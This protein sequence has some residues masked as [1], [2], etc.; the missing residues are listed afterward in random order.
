[1]RAAH[2]GCSNGEQQSPQTCGMPAL[3]TGLSEPRRTLNASLAEAPRWCRLV[4]G[5]WHDEHAHTTSLWDIHTP[6][7][8]HRYPKQ[9]TDVNHKPFA[10]AAA[11][12]YTY[13][14]HM[15]TSFSLVQSEAV[16]TTQTNLPMTWQKCW[17]STQ[18]T[19]PRRLCLRQVGMHTLYDGQSEVQVSAWT[20]SI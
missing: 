16:V 5:P 10:T 18:V 7:H 20:C 15:C 13:N 2:A 6:I 3:D 11:G 8:S 14:T 12:P 9:Q 4:K 1:M 19:K 17:T